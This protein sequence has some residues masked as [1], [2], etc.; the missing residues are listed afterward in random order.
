[1]S[2][3]LTEKI[4]ARASGQNII[5]PGD[6]VDVDVNTA[7]VHD[8]FISGVVEEFSKLPH[9]KVWNPNNI[10]FIA[11]HEVPAVSEWAGEC[12]KTMLRFAEE[13]QIKKVH[14]AEGVCHQ[15]IPEKGY[16]GPGMVLVG[17][18]SHSTTHGALGAFAS[19]IGTT[20]MASVLATGKI[21]LR[22]PETI[23]FELTGVLPQGVYAKDIVLSMLGILGAEGANYKAIEITGSA[24]ENLSIAD[25]LTIC[26]MAVE[27]GA[28]NALFAPDEK[29]MAYIQQSSADPS[30]ITTID[31][32]QY[33]RTINMHL[34][35]I[36]PMLAF[37]K[38]VDDIH[39]VDEAIGREIHEAFIGSCTNGRY[40][41]FVV[42][43]NIIRGKRIPKHVR[44]IITPASMSIYKRLI[45]DG[46]ALD[47]IDA[48]G[49]ITNPG[50]GLCYGKH[51]GVLSKT[52]VAITSNNRNF[53]GRLGHKDSKVYLASPATVAWSAVNGKISDPMEC[54]G[55]L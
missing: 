4:L 33:D 45:A 55:L 18:D 46:I 9:K 52:D 28:K 36:K 50:C 24:V 22:V 2:N 20:E 30:F 19:G 10:V 7:F 11:D 35:D 13:Q 34:N 51:G 37:P 27:M 40:E 12:Y 32:P 49:M 26:N 29:T 3:T 8:V 48:G 15:L 21:W 25:R 39:G 31:A 6:I 43:A 5:T 47:F 44:L 41:D 38:G 1:M 17:T 53:P 54:N 14:I 23:H 42:A 16:I